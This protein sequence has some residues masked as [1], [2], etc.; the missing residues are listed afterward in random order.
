MIIA[1][2]SILE[3]MFFD[4]MSKRDAV[5]FV[6]LRACP[7]KCYCIVQ[8]LSDRTPACV[9]DLELELLLEDA[10]VVCFELCTSISFHSYVSYSVNKSM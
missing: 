8:S 3:E 10:G 1:A 7:V 5:V 2:L 6:G 9:W 4:E